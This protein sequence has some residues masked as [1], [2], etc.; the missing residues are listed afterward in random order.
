MDANDDVGVP[1]HD[2]PTSP[3][4]LIWAVVP[5]TPDILNEPIPAVTKF[6]VFPTIMIDPLVTSAPSRLT[7]PVRSRAW[8]E[9]VLITVSVVLAAD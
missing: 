2:T 4:T 7:V 5:F 1:E 9:P 3:F 8:P 6:K